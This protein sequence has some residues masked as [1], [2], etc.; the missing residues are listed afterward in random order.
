MRLTEQRRH[1]LAALQAEMRGAEGRNGSALL[2]Q[3]AQLSAA[4]LALFRLSSRLDAL[5]AELV[6]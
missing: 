5:L 4:S 2:A 1:Q 6:R 3:G